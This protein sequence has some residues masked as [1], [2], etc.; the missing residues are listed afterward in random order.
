MHLLVSFV[1][2]LKCA[3]I[4]DTNFE[5]TALFCRSA[6]KTTQSHSHIIQLLETG[7]YSWASSIHLPSHTLCPYIQLL[8]RYSFKSTSQLLYLAVYWN[9]LFIHCVIHG[10]YN[11]FWQITHIEWNDKDMNWKVQDGQ[12]FTAK[13]TA[14][15][16]DMPGVTGEIHTISESDGQDLKTDPPDTR[17]RYSF[18]TSVRQLGFQFTFSAKVLHILT[19]QKCYIHGQ[20]LH[21]ISVKLL[22][23]GTSQTLPTLGTPHLLQTANRH[24]DILVCTTALLLYLAVR[25]VSVTPCYRPY[26]YSMS[27]TV[28]VSS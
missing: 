2:R 10:F 13:R 18:L 16:M 5:S 1:S 8:H 7:P 4:T 24:S 6:D 15:S 14:L 27:K 25:T 23:T 19:S 17:H 11:A 20:I 21:L 12:E 9:Q 3:S 22:R 26:T 28:S